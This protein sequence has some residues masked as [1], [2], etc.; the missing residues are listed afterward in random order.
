MILRGKELS[1][2]LQEQLKIKAQKL[3]SGSYIAI[4]FFGEDYSSSTYVKHKQKYWE[5]IWITTKI[6][7]EEN[8]SPL[9]KESWWLAT[10][11]LK[12]I[13]QLNDDDFCVGIIVQLPLPENLKEQQINILS[14]ISP[15]K[16]ID[17]MWG[18][19]TGLSSVW[20]IDFIPAT[21]KAVL[22]LLDHYNLWNM[23]NKKVSIIWQSNIVGRPLI[24]ECIKR[25]ATVASFNIENT[26]EEIQNITKQSDYIISCTGKVH[27]LDQNYI[28]MD[29]SQIIVDVGYWHI[30]GKPVGDVNIESIADH[31]AAY[32]P[33]PG[34]IWPLTVA[35][36]FDNIFT[37]Q[38]YKKVLERYK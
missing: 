7:T 19:N 33:V 14:A 8:F 27:L 12:L 37:L 31:V 30:D 26:Q 18:V 32:T 5:S 34:G 20:L 4:L 3:Q 28:R 10:R 35:C 6:F 21:P 23:K 16:D 38:E 11:V 9:I 25:W 1:L 36:L 29:N 24:F 22:I 13:K 17:W 15:L 2:S